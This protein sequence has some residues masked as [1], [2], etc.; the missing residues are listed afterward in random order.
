LA[1]VTVIIPA[2]TTSNIFTSHVIMKESE[3]RIMKNGSYMTWTADS[4]LHE[5]PVNKSF[6]SLIKNPQQLLWVF[7]F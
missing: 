6:H 2:G 5:Y 7:V 1:I 3:V 4:F